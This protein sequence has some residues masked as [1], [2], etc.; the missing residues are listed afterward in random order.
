[1]WEL[2]L[3]ATFEEDSV[4][5]VNGCGVDGDVVHGGLPYHMDRLWLWVLR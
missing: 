5:R 2:C 3:A 1:M 4:K